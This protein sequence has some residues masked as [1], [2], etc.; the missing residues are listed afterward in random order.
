MNTEVQGSRNVALG[1]AAVAGVAFLGCVATFLHSGNFRSD[2]GVFPRLIAIVGAIA[3]L[4]VLAN[5]LLDLRR[6]RASSSESQPGT[7]SLAD[8]VVAYVGPA[9]YGLLLYVTGFWFASVVCL[10]ALMIY[11]GER[12]WLLMLMITVGTMLSIYVV[13][14]FAF[15]IRMPEGLLLEWWRDSTSVPL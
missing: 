9:V 6:R 10:P 2:G 12:R 8:Q 5:A 11:L 14:T 4:V 1:T 15:S 7:L 13:F 3:A